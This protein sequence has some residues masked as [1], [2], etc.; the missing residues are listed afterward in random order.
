[1]PMKTKITQK[2]RKTR[3]MGLGTISTA[4]ML[5]NSWK[6]HLRRLTEWTSRSAWMYVW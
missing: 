3:K 6:A 4:T 1:M 2:I 5:P